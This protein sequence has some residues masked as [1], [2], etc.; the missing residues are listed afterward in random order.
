MKHKNDS[1]YKKEDL[2]DCLINLSHNPLKTL[3][4]FVLFLFFVEL[5]LIALHFFAVTILGPAITKDGQAALFDLSEELTFA[6]WFS[7]MQLLILSLIGLLLAWSRSE[8]KIRWLWIGC[9]VVFLFMSL[10]ETSGIHEAFSG[11]MAKYFSFV[12]LR[13]SIWWAI[14]YAVVLSLILAISFFC[15][16]SHIPSI[17]GLILGSTCW[18]GAVIAE[19]HAISSNDALSIAIEEGLEMAGTTFL[20]YAYGYLLI[21][22]R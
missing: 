7:S 1:I 13:G 5:I 21:K 8:E 16:L 4:R 9:F 10:D 11:I 17:V 14:P 18:V 22:A 20:I 15:C 19:I 12:P 3:L 6:V 2:V